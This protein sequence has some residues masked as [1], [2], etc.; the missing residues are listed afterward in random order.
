[1]VYH[2]YHAVWATPNIFSSHFKFF[3]L[4]KIQTPLLLSS[5]VERQTLKLQPP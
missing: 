5:L 4:I 3:F 1:M 2:A